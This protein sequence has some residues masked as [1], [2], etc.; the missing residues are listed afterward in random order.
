MGKSLRNRAKR[1]LGFIV[2]LVVAVLLVTAVMHRQEIEDHFRASNFDPSTRA[3]E[4][5][6]TLQLTDTGERVFLASQPTVDGSQQ[7]N[8]QCAEVDHSEDGHILG[9][10][11][12][13]RIHLFDVS[14]ERIRGIVEV[15]A[16]HELLHAMFARM[17]EGD[18]RALSDK[19]RNTYDVMSVEQP[20]LGERMAVYEH[21]SDAAF[22]NELHSVLG[23]EVFELPDWLE[24]HYAQWFEDREA[25]VNAFDEYHAVFV[26]LQAQ[27]TSIEGEMHGLR[28]D[29]E[30]RNAAYDDAVEQFNLDAA[31]FRERNERFEFGENPEEF[32]RIQAELGQRRVDLQTTLDTLQA[33]IDHYN[34]LR[35]QLSELSTLSSDLDQQLNS[36]LAP[37]TTRPET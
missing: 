29:V 6:E 12:E 33:D 2:F 18:R 19:L 8:E 26:E 21:L 22:A 10:F 5:M 31:N 20:E 17:G 28:E 24:E 34:S 32:D 37:V 27:A 13:E 16:A 9:C 14:D 36:D 15:T 7:F 35:D 23:T 30:S 25:I 11:V 1:T 4:V 3:V